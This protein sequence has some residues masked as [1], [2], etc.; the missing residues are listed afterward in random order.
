MR[1]FEPSPWVTCEGEIAHGGLCDYFGP[2]DGLIPLLWVP[3]H[4]RDESNNPANG[5]IRLDCCPLC[6][7]VLSAYHGKW[8]TIIP[9][10]D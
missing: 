5:A 3:E 6:A 10:G 1:D 4:L 9:K 2:P 8:A 7:E